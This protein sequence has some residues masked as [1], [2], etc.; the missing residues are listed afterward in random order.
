MAQILVQGKT[1]NLPR[2]DGKLVS[3]FYAW[4]KA[5]VPDPLASIAATLKDLPADIARDLAL[6]AYN[7]RLQPLAVDSDEIQ[8]VQQTPEGVL[9]LLTLLLKRHQPDITEEQVWDFHSAAIAEHGDKYLVT[10]GVI[11]E[12]K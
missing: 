5:R 9:H 2:F 3:E 8:A 4:A 11:P 12:S 7:R 1:Y 10:S 6:A